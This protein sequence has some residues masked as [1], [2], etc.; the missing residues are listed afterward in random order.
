MGLVRLSFVKTRSIVFGERRQIVLPF[1]KSSR[2]WAIVQTKIALKIVEGNFFGAEVPW[3]V[4]GH[5][6]F[7]NGVQ[8]ND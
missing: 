7:L 3:I 8:P 5:T 6:L 1:E 2:V 4:G